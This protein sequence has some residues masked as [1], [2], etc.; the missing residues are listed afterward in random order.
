MIYPIVEGDGEVQA[1]PVLLRR[2]IPELGGYIEIGQSI[3]RH[4]SDLVIEQKFK[5]TI[6]EIVLPKPELEAL[7]ILFDA[8]EDC[9]RNHV[10]QMLAWVREVASHVPCAIVMARREYEAWFLASIESLRGV[11]GISLNAGY[12]TDPEQKSDAK[13]TVRRFTPRNDPYTPTADQPA[14]SAVFD[15][16]QAYRRASSFRKLVKE[17]CRVLTELGQQPEIPA[18]WVAE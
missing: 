7:L 11:R 10:P 3:K 14:L 18:D 12:R 4:R 5:Y 8:D 9:A 6:Q 15:F 1:V 13:G 17:L 2:L 16:S